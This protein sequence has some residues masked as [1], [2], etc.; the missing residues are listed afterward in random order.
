MPKHFAI[1]AMG[2]TAYTDDKFREELLK[3]INQFSRTKNT[4]REKWDAFAKHVSFQV[5]DINQE[6]TYQEQGER[7]ARFAQEAGDEPNVIYYRR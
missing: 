2:R 4:P 1:V 7:I 5:S 3:D 6:S